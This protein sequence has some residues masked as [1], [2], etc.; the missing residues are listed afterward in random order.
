[1][2]LDPADVRPTRH[3][4]GA[5]R[6]SPRHMCTRFSSMPNTPSVLA[7]RVHK[8]R[9][10]LPNPTWTARRSSRAQARHSSFS[11]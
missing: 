6:P 9:P 5:A 10:P 4:I 7:P 8:D 2:P 3:T 1:M 11:R